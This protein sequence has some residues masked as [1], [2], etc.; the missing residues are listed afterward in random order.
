MAFQSITAEASP[1]TPGRRLLRDA[2]YVAAAIGAV[3]LTSTILGRAGP[4]LV[5]VVAV[6]LATWIRGY[7]LEGRDVGTSSGARIVILVHTGAF[8][9]L[10]LAGIVLGPGG[11][12]LLG[13]AMIVGLGFLAAHYAA[14][15]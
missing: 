5:S 12:G 14:K 8:V 9:L 15:Q 6:L 1:R 13:A 7:V 3:A 10:S 2:P 11:V 4:L